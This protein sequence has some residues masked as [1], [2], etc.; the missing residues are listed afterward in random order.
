MFSKSKTDNNNNNNDDDD[1]DDDDITT[2]LIC[3]TVNISTYTY[4]H[5]YIHTQRCTHKREP[6]ALNMLNQGC[7]QQREKI[8]CQD[9]MGAYSIKTS[10]PIHCQLRINPTSYLQLIL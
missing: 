10:N 6:I 8:R 1:D 7:N 4:I 9:P 5:T 2:K 3:V